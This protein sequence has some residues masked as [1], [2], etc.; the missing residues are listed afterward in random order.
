MLCFG[1][2]MAP[3]VFTT[4]LCFFSSCAHSQGIRLLHFLDD[5]LILAS[6]GDQLFDH[7]LSLYQELGII[8]NWEKSE[9]VPSQWITYL[10][11]LINLIDA[12]VFPIASC[13]NELKEM[14]E[15]FLS[16]FTC[17]KSDS[18]EITSVSTEESLHFC[19]WS[20]PS[21]SP[22][23]PN[24]GGPGLETKQW[25]P[26]GRGPFLPGSSKDA[27]KEEWGAKRLSCSGTWF[28]E[29]RRLQIN[30]LEM[31]GILLPLHTFQDRL[32]GHTVKLIEL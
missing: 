17:G 29:E 12:L 18:N 24:Q 22:E 8:V 6:F 13:I 14:M 31:Y 28:W 7:L 19:R 27:S 5:W 15:Y 23:P 20:V 3:Q 4:L 11:M 10:A 32:I 26:K 25:L 2:S 9:L 21:S 16:G 30:L 1:L